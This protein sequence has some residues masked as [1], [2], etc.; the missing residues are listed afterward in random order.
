MLKKKQVVAA[1]ICKDGKILICQRAKAKTRGLQWEFVGGKVERGETLRQALIRECEEE[2]GIRVLPGEI[3]SE[4]D[5]AYDD[6]FIHITLFNT[7]ILEGVPQMKEHADIKWI[8]IKDI[9]RYRLSDADR[10][11]LK[12]ISHI[13]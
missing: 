1:L 9:F 6:M 3:F 13:T 7:E 11:L 8:P 4:T 5:Y 12:K 2:L 10:L